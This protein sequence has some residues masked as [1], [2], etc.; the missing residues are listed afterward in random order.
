MSTETKTINSEY[1]IWPIETHSSLICDGRITDQII[2]DFGVNVKVRVVTK[3]SHN[4]YGDATK[5]YSDTYSKAYMHLW[6][7]NDDEV[8]QGI[9]K[10]GEIMFVFKPADEVKIKT[11]NLI[12][13]GREWYKIT[14]I[15]PQIFSGTLYLIN[16]IVRK[17]LD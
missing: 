10:N 15:Q 12:F 11:G 1:Y 7:A 14:S 4:I 8:K 16:A 9:F 6:T 5:A 3:S 2:D 17:Y 13:Y